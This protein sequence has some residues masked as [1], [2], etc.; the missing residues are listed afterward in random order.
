MDAGIA[1]TSFAT[2]FETVIGPHYD[3][4]VRRLAFIVGDPEEAKDLAQA[5]YLRAFEA[6]PRFDGSDA[7]AWVYTIGINLAVSERRRRWR[8]RR[9]APEVEQRWA[10]TVD[11]DL[12]RAIADLDARHRAALLLSV[13][14]GYT[15]A[16][17]AR[18]LRVPEGTVASWLSRSKALLRERLRE[19]T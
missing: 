4:L 12:W 18:M 10:I 6:W 2:P 8:W 17:V 5:A 1:V 19:V 15:Q 14:D 7:R 16:E 11:P 9:R 3:A 13:L